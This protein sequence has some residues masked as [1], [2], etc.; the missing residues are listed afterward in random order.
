M[1]EVARGHIEIKTNIVKLDPITGQAKH[2]EY[3]PNDT[4][5]ERLNAR[6]AERAKLYGRPCACPCG[7][8]V[9]HRFHGRCALC[10]A[11]D[12][13]WGLDAYLAK[14]ETRRG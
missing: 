13:W 9:T 11:G 4:V 1:P 7:C 14:I 6:I 10:R 5:A 8:G 2:G 3:T 12:C